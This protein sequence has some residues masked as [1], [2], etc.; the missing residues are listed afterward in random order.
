[1]RQTEFNVFLAVS[2]HQEGRNVYHLTA[3]SNVALANQTASVVNGLCQ[4]ST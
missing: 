3:H 1:M 4:A 2:T